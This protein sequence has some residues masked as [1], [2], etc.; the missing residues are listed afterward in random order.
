MSD[1]KPILDLPSG[2]AAPDGIE[3]GRPEHCPVAP[4]GLARVHSNTTGWEVSRA[5]QHRL[6]E[7]PACELKILSEMVARGPPLC[8]RQHPG[9]CPPLTGSRGGESSVTEGVQQWV[10]GRLYRDSKGQAVGF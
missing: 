10:V 2:S 1:I 6:P 9:T 4:M 8:E 5:L 3:A 7:A